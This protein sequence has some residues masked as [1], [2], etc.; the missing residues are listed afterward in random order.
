MASLFVPAN[1]TPRR[2]PSL[3]PAL[4]Q[5][6]VDR[7]AE[8]PAFHL[9]ELAPMC[10]VKEGRRPSPGTIQRVLADGPPPTRSGRRYLPYREMAD[11]ADARYA[12]VDLHREGWRVSTIAAYLECSRQ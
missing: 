6:I 5:L 12:I 3:S 8:Y 1:E 10:Y 4:R 9:R 7:K 2:G 11:P